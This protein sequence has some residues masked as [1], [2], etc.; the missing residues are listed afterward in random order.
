[1]ATELL[2]YKSLWQMQKEVVTLSVRV[3][4]AHVTHDWQWDVTT[5]D[6]LCS[7]EKQSTV[8][9]VSPLAALMKN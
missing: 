7:C 9:V 8:V 3:R 1:M 6:V 2:G 5:R 4:H